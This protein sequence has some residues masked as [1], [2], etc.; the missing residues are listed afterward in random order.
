VFFFFLTSGLFLGWSLGANDAANIFGTAVGTKMVSFKRA[1]IIASIFVI[2]GAVIQGSG[3]TQTLGALG[4]ID[5]FAG[6]FTVAL[7]A[8]LT[9]FAMT[10]Y[11]LPVSTTQAIVGAIIGWNLFAKRDTDYEVLS[12]IVSTWIS[13]PILGAAF[14]ALLYILMRRVLK[15]LKIHV[16]QLDSYIRWG[17]IAVGAFGAYSLGANNIAN[18]IGVFV[19]G[20]PNIIV[21]FGI[22]SLDGTQLLFLAGGIAISIGI[23]TYSKRIMETVGKG[24]MSLSA[25][26]A[27]VVVLAQAIVLFVFSSQSLS[28]LLVYI[29]LPRI[30]MVPVSS[31]QV[32]I[33][34]VLG[35]GLVK[36]VQEVRFK[37]LGG[38]ALGW[39][40]TPL[41]AGF[42]SFFSLFFVQ[43]VF[44]QRVF[45]EKTI[46]LGPQEDFVT[47]EIVQK[48]EP[49]H[50]NLI[51]LIAGIT[52]ILLF[53]LII[54]YVVRQNR[55][56]LK[57]QKELL[58]KQNEFYITEKALMEADLKA[59]KL[60]NSSLANKLEF[61]RREVVNMALSIVEQKNYMDEV[62]EQLRENQK[63]SDV[64]EKNTQIE[65]II[66]NIKLK[67]NYSDKVESFNIEVEKLHK[68]FS[69]RLE[70]QFP[71]LTENDKRLAALLRLGFS[72]KEIAPLLNISPKSA[73][74][75]RYRL[76][77][78]LNISKGDNL[79]RFIQSL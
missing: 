27:I 69:L 25:E 47:S 64:K 72:S 71:Q 67:T 55:L 17:L 1:A 38:I 16:I 57:A 75:S 60:E 19:G 24:I 66:R 31:S 35:I 61:R 39:V 79:I 2:L 20:A 4:M 43:N 46:N 36:G 49:E 74:I 42:L 70:E 7:A 29:G 77:K 51:W 76:R 33:G 73:E 28:N 18:V 22:F 21:D 26:A 23:F 65:A 54:Y 12:Q 34:A 63:I 13:G 48:V 3:T 53:T 32:V 44:N 50:F 52:I 9:V 62:I 41:I 59:I 40:L 68:G 45:S 6:S 5:E 10:K 78:K 11:G 8:G 58:D 37:T 15:R 30:P 56:K 14:S